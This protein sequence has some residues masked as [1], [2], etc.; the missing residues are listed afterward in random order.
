MALA[1]AVIWRFS[2]SPWISVRGSVR[3]ISTANC[4]VGPL[5]GQSVSGSSAASAVARWLTK[6]K[7]APNPASTINT[8]TTA[9]TLSGR[10]SPPRLRRLVKIGLGRRR[11]DM[12]LFRRRIVIAEIADPADRLFIG[13][14]QLVD[15]VF[16]RLVG[17]GVFR[18]GHGRD[19]GELDRAEAVQNP[20]LVE[21]LGR[22][23]R[24]LVAVGVAIDGQRL[25]S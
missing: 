2:A 3:S 10:D 4:E 22:W 9:A 16:Q 14:L 23:R 24:A 21:A 18:L 11:R 8:M 15:A 17:P 1:Q 25:P 7:R 19:L 5:F 20:D 6:K 13:G 12:G